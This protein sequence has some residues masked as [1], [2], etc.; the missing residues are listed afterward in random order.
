M[1]ALPVRIADRAQDYQELGIDPVR[2]EPFEDGMRTD[3]GPGTY[4]WWYFDAH[5]DD[6]AKLVVAFHLKP[7]MA[8]AGPMVPMV[9][10]NLDLP[11]GRSFERRLIAPADQFAAATDT[12]DVRIGTNT[13]VGDLRTYRIR[14]AVEEVSVDVELVGQVPSWRPGTGH[15]YFGDGAERKLFAW[16][17]SVPQGAVTVTYTVDDETHTTTGIGYHDHNWGDTVMSELMHDWYWARGQIGDYTVIASYIT[18]EEAYGYAPITIFLLAQD[19]KI[20]TDDATKVTF[21]T[22]RHGRDEV[23]GKPF[24]DVTRYDFRDRDERFAVS[25]T[26]DKTIVQRRYLNEM[27]AQ[28]RAVAEAN[29]FDGAYL[30]FSGPIRL[31]HEITGAEEYDA[32]QEAIWEL[33]YFGRPRPASV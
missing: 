6:G 31:V 5:L 30:R 16:L 12:C 33:M 1:N 14:A 2:I 26:R 15:F 22:D 29:G 4:E 24:A 17:P 32:T 8:V 11:D 9:T 3:G 23:T 21:S 25:F 7:I 28:D 19:G 10:I 20:L 18:A 13:F 27:S